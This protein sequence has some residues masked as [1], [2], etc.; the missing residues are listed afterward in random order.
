MT[1]SGNISPIE[2][3]PA[4]MVFNVYTFSVGFSLIFLL[5]VTEFVRKGTLSEQHSLFW[6]VF[7]LTMLLMA[8]NTRLLEFLSRLLH[9]YYAPSVLFLFG[10]LLITIYSFH[11]TII[12]SRQSEKL[13][14]L[15][16]EIA[17][18]KNKIE[19]QADKT[20]KSK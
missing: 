5:V 4:V 17:L 1:V 8:A 14:K 13:L 19:E 16:Q 6:F 3:R 18:L 11:L 12:V 10:F 15:T 20:V 7:A 2:A 9:I